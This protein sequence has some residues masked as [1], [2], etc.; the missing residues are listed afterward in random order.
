MDVFSYSGPFGIII[1][2]EEKY[3]IEK[4]KESISMLYKN[5]K[6]NNIENY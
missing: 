2:G 4:N 1:N 5:L 6:L 3:F